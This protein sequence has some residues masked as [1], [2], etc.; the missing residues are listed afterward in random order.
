MRKEA[1]IL[2]V[3]DPNN[4]SCGTFVEALKKALAGWDIT[5][6]APGLMT[7]LFEVRKYNLVH[8]FHSPGDKA[9]SFLKALPGNIRKV[10]TLL[11]P[12]A[13]PEDYR[14]LIVAHRAIVF[15]QSDREIAQKTVLAT[16]IEAIPPCAVVP[17]V[18][19]LQPS[20]EVRASFQVEDRMLV[21]ALSDVSSKE[22][23]D[24]FVYVT[25]EY[26]RRGGFRFLVPS[27]RNDKETRLW[28]RRVQQMVE[29]EKL[30]STT[31]IDEEI[32]LHSLIDSADMAVYLQK[33]R[34]PTFDFSLDVLEASAL[35][36]PV[37]CFDVPPYNETLREFVPSWICTNIEDFVRESH[38]LRKN[39]ASLEQTATDL[40]RFARE[41]FS[42]E[43]VAAQ[44]KAVYESVLKP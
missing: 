39:A 41:R 19:H 21:V 15:S 17:D 13:K 18:N 28:R 35:G 4:A 42:A 14:S 3:F 2:F 16:P 22:D 38:D 7:R 1:K 40:A 33:R 29:Q 34:N 36:K 8:S 32:D 27:Y 37:L 12:P 44:Y 9:A 5:I 43:K 6:G 20:T 23:F 25:R 30:T 24:G 31:F 26:N 10:Q 11:G